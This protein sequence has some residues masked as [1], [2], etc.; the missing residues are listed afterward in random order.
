VTAAPEA[1]RSKVEV[2]ALIRRER[3]RL[4]AAISRL[5][6]GRR[7]APL[8]DDGWSVKDVMAHVA[9]WESYVCRRLEARSRGDT[10]EVRADADAANALI[11]TANR[12]KPLGEVD[13][14]F[15]SAFDRIWRLIEGL[16]EADLLDDSRRERII[17]AWPSPVWLHV[18]G[19][20]WLHY[21]EHTEALER[22]ALQS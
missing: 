13:A 18:A 3:D 12:D 20:T 19:N 11:Y 15:R 5:P 1:P 21:A 6:E 9:D 22:V 17:G 2:L 8:L 10:P 14:E 7:A 4:E 16:S